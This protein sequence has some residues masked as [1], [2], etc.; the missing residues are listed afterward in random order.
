LVF[1]HCL[2]IPEFPGLRKNLGVDIKE[3]IYYE[4][5]YN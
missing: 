3:K 4:Y 1:L 2:G 5:K